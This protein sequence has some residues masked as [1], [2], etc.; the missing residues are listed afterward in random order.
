MG[1]LGWSEGPGPSSVVWASAL[2]VKTPA[3]A[4]A[5]TATVAINRFFIT[6]PLLTLLKTFRRF[7]HQGY[8]NRHAKDGDLRRPLTRVF[9]AGRSAVSHRDEVA[10]PSF[11]PTSARGGGFQPSWGVCRSCISR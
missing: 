7:P 9:S 4:K 5:R 11:W 10:S 6:H 8:G 3:S 1:A 2:R